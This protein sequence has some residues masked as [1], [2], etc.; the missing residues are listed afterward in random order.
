[1]WSNISWASSLRNFFTM[2]INSS[3]SV[4]INSKRQKLFYEK[5]INLPACTTFYCLNLPSILSIILNGLAKTENHFLPPWLVC[6]LDTCACGT[7][8]TRTDNDQD[9]VYFAETTLW[10]ACPE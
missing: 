4:T 9:Q 2:L 8:K 6:W 10:T 3:S 5:L 1:M 7:P